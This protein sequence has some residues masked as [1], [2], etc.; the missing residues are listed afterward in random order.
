M[1]VIVGYSID[2]KGRGGLDLART[3][4]E[5]STET[6]VVACAVAARWETV[7]AGRAVDRDYHEHLLSLARATL[8]DAE[9]LLGPTR[10]PVT[11]EVVK[12]RSVARTL[13]QAAA[14][15]E[16]SVLV[17][18]SGQAGAWGRIALG[19]VTDYLTHASPV[20]VVLAPRGHH[21][22]TGSRLERVTVAVRGEEE[23]FKVLE[24]ALALSRRW[25]APLR[26]LVFAVRGQTMWPPVG[27]LYAEDAIMRERLK[28]AQAFLDE[29][30][31][32]FPDAGIEG[33][34]GVGRNW[35]EAL[36]DPGWADVE[37]L[38]L[39]SSTESG[40]SRVFLGSTALRIVRVAPVPVVL[41][42]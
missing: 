29:V 5:S 33:T 11:Y 1:S 2:K 41:V 34:I 15:H 6:L 30:Q 40:A 4:A 17:L 39:G 32:R 24:E 20:P 28:D 7:S 25:R 31:A 19:S 38:V 22:P 3:L 8:S 37:V 13:L 21:W 10:V 26:V 16:A 12:G 14:E 9:A 35:G 23:S 42:P 18:G 36:E 27:G